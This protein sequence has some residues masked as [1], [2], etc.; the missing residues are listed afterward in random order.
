MIDDYKNIVNKIYQTR[1]WLKY[2][3]KIIGWTE[4]GLL[5]RF[6]YGTVKNIYW[7]IMKPMQKQ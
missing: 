3:R 4:F 7:M 6:V 5:A 2:D 1:N